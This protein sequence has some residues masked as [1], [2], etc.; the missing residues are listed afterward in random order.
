MPAAP[1]KCK[2]DVG[3]LIPKCSGKQTFITKGRQAKVEQT[4]RH[5]QAKK[6]GRKQVYSPFTNR[7]LM[8]RQVIPDHIGRTGRQ[9]SVRADSS[10]LVMNIST[11]PKMDT[12]MLR[13]AMDIDIVPALFIR[14]VSW[15]GNLSKFHRTSRLT[16]DTCISQGG[17]L[18][19]VSWA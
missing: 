7:V 18:Q 4:G 16:F 12:T 5:E 11:T 6:R 17:K 1:A 13:S 14:R 9:A 2:I 15:H 8:R 19:H 3:L 10:G